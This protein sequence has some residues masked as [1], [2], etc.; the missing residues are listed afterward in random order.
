MNASFVLIGV[1]MLIGTIFL[2]RF[3]PQGKL[4]ITAFVLL[5]IASVGKIM[6]GLVPENTIIALHTTG[7]LNIPLGNIAILLLGISLLPRYRAFAVSG[8]IVGIVGLCAT[9][10]LGALES[11]HIGAMLLSLGYG[12]MERL[13]GYPADIWILFLGI[14][15]ARE[16]ARHQNQPELI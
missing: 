5:I 3:F 16:G 6:V 10:G 2:K 12:E 7:A 9:L 8:I 4:G 15:A 1:L 11:G 14:C 13:A